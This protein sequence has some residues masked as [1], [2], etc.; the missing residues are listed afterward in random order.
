SLFLVH[1]LPDRRRVRQS[2]ISL[3][4]RLNKKPHKAI[5]C[6]GSTG[7]TTKKSADRCSAAVN[8]VF[9]H[10]HIHVCCP[11]ISS[12]HVDFQIKN[13]LEQFRNIEAR[14]ANSRGTAARRF[15]GF[16]EIEQCLVRL[17]GAQ[18]EQLVVFFRRSNPGEF[19]PVKLNF[20][21]T[22]QLGEIDWRS[23]RSKSEPIWFSYSI[24]IVGGGY[25][26]ATGHIL[27]DDIR[28]AGNLFGQVMSD[29]AGVEITGCTRGNARDNLYPFTLLTIALRLKRRRKATDIDN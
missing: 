24:N 25:G 18:E 8:F 26:S 6:P 22:Q 12:D 2:M 20:L 1:Q 29:H 19:A 9:F 27:H 10:S 4:T 23:N 3:V 5:I 14:A 17:I 28:F 16:A 21:A 7:F 15:A 13:L 11:W